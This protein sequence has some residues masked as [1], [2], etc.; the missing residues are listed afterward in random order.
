MFTETE[1]G[2]K[3]RKFHLTLV[4]SVAGSQRSRNFFKPLLVL[5][6]LIKPLEVKEY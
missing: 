5:S 3:S 6:T 4:M 2:K 1:A